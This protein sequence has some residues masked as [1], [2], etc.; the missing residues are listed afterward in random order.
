MDSVEYGQH[1][2]S[3]KAIEDEAAY[4]TDGM[5]NIMGLSR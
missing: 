5:A 2:I 4:L 3:A 1:M